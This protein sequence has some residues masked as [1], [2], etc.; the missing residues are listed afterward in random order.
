M[1]FGPPLIRHVIRGA[2][3]ADVPVSGVEV[4]MHRQVRLK[5]WQLRKAADLYWRCYWP[6]SSG[7]EL[8]FD[9][10]THPMVPGWLYLIAPH[11]RFDSKCDRPFQKWYIHFTVSGLGHP[12]ESGI[13][14]IRPTTRMRHLLAL[15]CPA[16]NDAVASTAMPKEIAT[17]ELIALALESVLQKTT[18]LPDTNQRI[19]A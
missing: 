13:V 4:L 8:V 19:A 12:C 10:K 6:L 17:I 7:G 1:N 14:R 5:Q 9:S 18:G 2:H 15:T 16:A 11:T 3:L